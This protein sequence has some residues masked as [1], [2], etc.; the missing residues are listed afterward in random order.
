MSQPKTVYTS[1]KIIPSLLH[2]LPVQLVRVRT[3]NSILGFTFFN[4][5]TDEYQEEFTV[6]YADSNVPNNQ[7]ST[8]SLV[9]AIGFS[10]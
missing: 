3:S 8:K 7:L 4:I 1:F 5:V 9:L 10:P 6:I 2:I